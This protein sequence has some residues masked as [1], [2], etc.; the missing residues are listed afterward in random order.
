MEIQITLICW[1]HFLCVKS[2]ELNGLGHMVD[3]FW[4][5]QGISILS[6]MLQHFTSH[7]H[8]I[9]VPFSCMFWLLSLLSKIPPEGST[10][11]ERRAVSAHP[12]LSAVRPNRLS[13]TPLPRAL[14]EVPPSK[15]VGSHVWAWRGE[16]RSHL[17]QI[18]FQV[19]AGRP[20]GKMGTWAEVCL[21]LWEPLIQPHT[22][23]PPLQRTLFK[24]RR[25]S[26]LCNVTFFN[27]TQNKVGIIFNLGP[28]SNPICLST[29]NIPVAQ[30]ASWK[31]TG[32]HTHQPLQEK[33]KLSAWSTSDC[34][35]CSTWN[36]EHHKRMCVTSCTGGSFCWMNHRPL[37]T[38][39]LPFLLQGP[40][41][42]TGHA[43]STPALGLPW[44]PLN[45]AR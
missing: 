31:S 25:I 6:S 43:C 8:W 22:P 11:I 41:N 3:L 44:G 34:F 20:Q 16:F 17:P 30:T 13:G 18:P 39:L 5:P 26:Y 10:A 21:I 40:A 15:M 19:P 37:R 9:R 33:L 27:I 32:D 45:M 2:Q 7:Q 35:I 12:N 14:T 24:P 42:V 29:K 36:L 28:T 4:D 23:N 1:F 38:N